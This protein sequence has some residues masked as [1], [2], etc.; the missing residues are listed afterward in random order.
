MKMKSVFKKIQI[1]SILVSSCV[2]LSGCFGRYLYI[3]AEEDLRYREKYGTL[4]E[5][6]TE[7]DGY[8][9]YWLTSKQYPG[10]KDLPKYYDE[11]GEIHKIL[12]RA[13]FKEINNK[14]YKEKRDRSLDWVR[15]NIPYDDFAY[16]EVYANGLGSICI[17]PDLNPSVDTY[18]KT[19]L[20]TV[21]LLF[22]RV[23]EILPNGE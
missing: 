10:G 22:L 7:F 2:F 1:A 3:A 17:A 21:E 16:I 15:Y 4:E 19:D 11:N 18:F 13:S 8:Q 9:R 23:S 12:K 14:T 6:L 5:C 20:N